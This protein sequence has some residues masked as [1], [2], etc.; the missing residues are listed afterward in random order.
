[1]ESVMCLQLCL[2]ICKVLDLYGLVMHTHSHI[3][4]RKLDRVLQL[5][6]DTAKSL[7]ANGSAAFIW[8][9]H[10]HWLKGLQQHHVT[11]IM[12]RP[13]GCTKHNIELNW[14]SHFPN[15]NLP[16]S[17]FLHTN[18]SYVIWVYDQYWSCTCLVLYRDIIL[19]VRLQIQLSGKFV[20]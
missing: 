14:S 6:S 16:E 13:L 8:K 10:C 19:H 20:R 9:L 4:S 7:L 2:L 15:N 18:R 17:M 11:V 5:Q 12:Y 1:M 3:H